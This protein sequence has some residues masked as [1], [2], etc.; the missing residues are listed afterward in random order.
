MITPKKNKYKL[1]IFFLLFYQVIAA[2]TAPSAEPDSY[3]TKTNTALKIDSLGV[4]ANDKDLDGDLLKVTAFS[5][6]G[7]TYSPGDTA[8]LPE[9]TIS[10]K[11]NGG[12][13]YSP[14]VDYNDITLI[15]NYTISDGTYTDS[16]DLTLSITNVNSPEA[17]NDIYTT[18]TNADLNIYAPGLL[19]NDADKDE[20]TL[21]ITAFKIDTVSYTVGEKAVFS[22]GSISINADGSFFFT[23]ATDYNNKIRTINYTVTD[24]TFTDSANLNIKIINLY[25]P[26]AKDNYDTAEINTTLKVDAP[27]VL[28]ND[29]DQDNNA[30]SVIQFIVNEKTYNIGQ[31]A[32][33]LEGSITFKADGSYTFIPAKDYTGNVPVIKYII[34]DGT[35]TAA[36][37]LFLTVEHITNLIEIKSLSSCNQGYTVDGMYKIKYYTTLTNTS[38]ARDYHATNL[39][40]KIDLTNDLNAIYGNGCVTQI[41]GVSINTTAVKD[42]VGSPYPLEFNNDAINDDFLNATSN[43]IFN[44]NAINNFTL[45]PRQSINIEFCVIVNPF[46]NGRPTPTPSGSGINFNHVLE[47]T[48][49]IGSH[50]TDLLLKDF[51]TTEAILAGGLYIPVPKPTVNPDGTFDYTNR[52]ILT[53]E[54]TAT[55]QNINY[56]MGLGNFLDK[57]IVFN[58]LKVTQIAGPPVTVNNAYNGNTNTQLLMPN[59][60]L[61]AGETIILE[62]FYLTAPFSSSQ[63]NHF[64]QLELSQTQG[65]LDG[66][67]ETTSSNNKNYSFVNWSDSLGKHLDRYYPTS[68]PVDPVSSSLQCSCSSSSMVFLFSSLT[69]NQ[70]TISKVEKIPNGILEHQ[71]I[72]FQLT[73]KNTSNIVQLENLQL[74]DNLKNICSGNI[75]SVST[76]FIESSTATTNPTLNPEY[77]GTSD[78]EFFNGTSGI[79]MK[80]ES[81]TVQFSVILNE[82]CLGTNTSVFSAT[83]PLNRVISSSG[84]VGINAS[85]DTDND[86]IT[87][88]TDIDD[89]ND[90]IRDIDE[91]NG[92]NPLDDHDGDLTPNY[93]DTDY[94]VDANN[95]GI[96][97]LFDF[98]NDGVPN[99]FD[100]DSDNDGILD[101][102][103][104]GNKASDTNRTGRTNK[105]VGTNGLD[106]TVENNDSL[107]T[108][109][110]YTIPNTDR[111]NT[112]NF[113]D[114][115]ADGDGIVDN[116]EGQTTTN[117]KA[118]NGIITDLGIDTAY[119]NGI[120]PTDTDRDATPDYVDINSDN[121]I[122]NDAIEGWDFNNDGIAETIP[123]NLDSDNDGLDNAF[124]TNNTILNPTN[125][126]VPTDFPNVDTPDGDAHDID[127]DW[128]EIIAIVVRID[129]VT[130]NESE[131]AIF[132]ISLVKK[133]EPTKQIQSAT[134]IQISFTTEDGTA[135]TDKYNIAIA[136]FDYNKTT[137]ATLTIPPFTEVGNFTVATFNDLINELD[138]L[139]TLNG[140]ITSNNTI[141]T[142]IS[143]F[144]TILDDDEVPS[145]TMNNAISNEGEDLEHTVTI[146]NPSSRP[147]YIDINTTNGSAISPDD[148]N[149]FYTTLT[150]EETTNPSNPNTE[151]S[152]NIPTKIDDL[153]EPNEF[154]NVLGVA[155]ST[156]VGA[157]DL[158]K[159]GIIIDINPEPKVVIN[160]VTVIEG[161]TLVFTISLV[162]PNSE[163]PMQNSLPINFKLKS[164]NETAS[165]LQDFKNLTT[166]SSIPAYTTSIT[167]PIL[168]IDDI[169]NED[170]E[171]MLLQAT[172]TSTDISNVTPV[173]YGIGTIQDNDVPNLFSPNGD[174]KSDVFEIDGMSKFPYFKITI[175]D[176]WGSEVYSY[177]NNGNTNPQWWDGTNNGTPVTEGVYYYTINFNDGITNP[178]RSF[179]QLIR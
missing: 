132:T 76:P 138:E 159:T 122:R 31:T 171:T 34:S 176:R 92:L 59:N 65:G 20:N 13:N 108:S 178:K 106:N 115:D 47:V 25:P 109:T 16:T 48:S 85:T 86:G 179:I 175:M 36:A 167:Q 68:S 104:A 128:R 98:D 95:D 89:D 54:G 12:F 137:S 155:A 174:G 139:F 160:D 44:Q 19:D 166:T 107:T 112:P 78:I 83:D 63:I 3:E 136:P 52:V 71:E 134:P 50:S 43:S 62:I 75:V 133:N 169:L 161:T 177:N 9:G 118:P 28:I 163:E 165:D 73:I 41:E 77:N 172:I 124:D 80:G 14:A 101:I 100:L 143:G 69:S 149:S 140:K 135:T 39:I 61:A 51:H 8:N 21:S 113:I 157:Q 79:L 24:G 70:K 148:Y 74:Q 33:F 67:D 26:E 102:V 154:L 84:S 5:A 66:F 168:T 120:T 23:P 90:T 81:I 1:L 144:A 127:R 46:C 29:K 130:V 22:E 82:D 91:Y 55:A 7:K 170:T 72:T 162:N 164:V 117:Y 37:N 121:D 126:Q 116:I 119:P 60:S 2:Q 141:N 156:N 150:I 17:K 147:I 111:S 125:G 151:T 49:T 56:N 32:T 10:I 131:D 105:S 129:N 30:L 35:F 6:N 99:H 57:R 88:V 96:V 110:N 58:E 103:E 114:I 38:T 45:Y 42:Y 15:V 94:G 11:A 53:N 123:L 145:I 97:D 142:E 152:F 173:L 27:G 40:K 93:R 146:S 153:N 87:N 18:E 4:L 158:T 64:K